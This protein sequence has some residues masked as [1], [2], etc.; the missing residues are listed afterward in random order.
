MGKPTVYLLSGSELEK[1]NVIVR[2]MRRETDQAIRQI[3]SEDMTYNI[4]ECRGPEKR[5]RA[6]VTL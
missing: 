6:S 3:E 2:K 5:Q 4:N 1:K